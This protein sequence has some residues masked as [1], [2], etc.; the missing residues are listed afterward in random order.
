MLCPSVISRLG[1]RSVIL[2][3]SKSRRLCLREETCA[4]PTRLV[5]MG[6]KETW[7]IFTARSVIGTT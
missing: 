5:A 3:M 7:S 4:A 2:A 1:P 6:H